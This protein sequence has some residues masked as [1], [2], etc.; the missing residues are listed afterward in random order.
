MSRAG[1]VSYTQRQSLYGGLHLGEF[2][3]VA[4]DLDLGV[5][6]AQEL[7]GSVGEVPPEVAR[8]VE[9]FPGDGVGEE[10]FRGALR[11]TEVAQ[12]DAGATDVQL[13]GDPFGPWPQVP[14]EHGERLVGQRPA[15][16]DA[17]AGGVHLADRVGDGPDGSLG[18]AAEGDDLQARQEAAGLVGQ[19]DR[20]PVAG[21]QREP[22][23]AV[24]GGGLGAEPVA[25]HVELARHGVPHRD[26]EVADQFGPVG[27]VAAPVGPGK[28]EG[29][30]HGERSEQVV[31]GQVEAEPR[32]AEDAVVLGDGE[33]AV[34]VLDGVEGGPVADHHAL[35][36]AGGARGVD[37]VGEVVRVP[38]GGCVPSVPGGLLDEVHRDGR[39]RLRQVLE[40]REPGLGEDG[41]HARVRDDRVPARRGLGR[42]HGQVRAAGHEGAEDGDDLLPALVHPDGHRLTGAQPGS[43]QRP[44][45]TA[46]AGHELPVGEGEFGGADRD[47]VR[48]GPGPGE[49]GFVQQGVR[50]GAL[51]G[52]D[53]VPAC[54]LGRGQLDTGRCVPGGLPGLALGRQRPHERRVRLEHGV[55]HA[56]GERAL[57]DVPGQAQRVTAPHDLAVEPDLRRPGHGVRHLRG[58]ALGGGAGA[59]G[60]GEDDRHEHGRAGLAG[61]LGEH[62]RAGEQGVGQVF[63]E[64]FRHRPGPL[65]EAD[66]RVEVDGEEFKRGEVTDDA[67]DV[68]VQGGP[69]DRGH[70]EGEPAGPR[71]GADGLRV[72][73]EQGRR[74]RQ[75]APGGTF[76]EAVAVGGGQQDL[77]S[78]ERHA[79]TGSR[80]GPAVRG[81]AHA[82]LPALGEGQFR[83]GGQGV[84][85]LGPVG[86]VADV[87]F[88][89]GEGTTG[90]DAVAEADPRCL[91]QCGAAVAPPELGEQDAQAR[92]V[93]DEH[94]EGQVEHGPSGRPG[95][96]HGEEG[97]LVGGGLAGG[98]AG[99]GALQPRLGG[100]GGQRGQVVGPDRERGDVGQDLLVAVLVDDGAEHVVTPDQF[101]PHGGDAVGV[102]VRVL[103]LHVGVAADSPVGVGVG[104][105]DE[106]GGLD[107]REREGFV[108]AGGVGAECGLP[109]LQMAQDGFLVRAQFGSV[110]VREPALRRPEAQ[111]SVLGPQHHAVVGVSGQQFSDVHS[112]P[113]S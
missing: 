19:R 36:R 33:A 69:V 3:P 64:L 35:G 50:Q 21:Y 18:G 41:A 96:V 80:G 78:A 25:E 110:G 49:Y 101:P 103:Q 72:R 12:G 83:S 20:Y 60:A 32:D 88:G 48:C 43:R 6:P 56:V 34:D 24:V 77:Q 44:G 107:V 102:Q 82:G 62:L 2:D 40:F 11:V 97:P 73:G 63:E 70:V 55:R 79:V 90:Q 17:R 111:L 99:P 38:A 52:V 54:G 27:G 57:P 13:A 9:P 46:R 5:L 106:V 85:P 95:H 108:A 100:G 67:V 109:A 98:Q 23:G 7:D 16:R 58:H 45:E 14:V 81:V 59:Q 31:H 53:R 89:A 47:G 93:D 75:T 86:A 65:G 71:P 112:S 39:H 105:A 29:G 4:A 51:G 84:E 30:A 1:S 66:P 22:Q 8:A 26:P 94:V 42:V 74:H 91:R 10:P 15:V 37:D 92:V 61:Q 113:V 87:A 104:P 68:L 76:G 28:D